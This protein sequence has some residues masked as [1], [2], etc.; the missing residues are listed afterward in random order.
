MML[1]VSLFIVSMFTLAACGGGGGGTTPPATMTTI[2]S[3]DVTGSGVSAGG[4]QILDPAINSGQFTV[5]WDI[6]S[7]DPYHVDLYVSLDNVLDSSDEQFFSRNC[8]TGPLLTCT[9]LGSFT[10][11]Y[12]NTNMISCGTI[13]ATNPE[14][15]LSTLILSLPMSAHI[16]AEACDNTFTNC[17]ETPVEVEFM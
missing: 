2:N 11:H 9:D 8:G 1:R 7:S 10:C 15:S 4:G 13:S 5:D 16:I 17:V 3:F 14:K 12:T 6:S